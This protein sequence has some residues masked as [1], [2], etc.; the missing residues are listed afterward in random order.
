MNSDIDEIDDPGLRVALDGHVATVEFSRP[1]NNFFDTQLIGL[2]A[3]AMETLASDGRTRAVVWC[4]TGRHFCAGANFAGGSQDGRTAS[5]LY[6]E[7]LRLFS[8][9]LPIVAAVQGAAIGGGLGL[10]LVADFR[11]ASSDARISANFAQLGFHHGFGI[12]VTLPRIVGHQSAM[13]LLYTGR[14]IKGAEALRIGL[15]DQITNPELL[16]ETAFALAGEIATSAPLAVRSIRETL[17]G[18]LTNEVALAVV[19]EQAEQERLMRTLDFREGI[20]AATDR[21]TPN[22]YGK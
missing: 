4:S 19:R 2:I 7:G 14:R 9:P 15:V 11:V 3:D 5:D 18:S 6:K 20:A 10:A 13:D 21:R 22:F 12:S 8:Q 16:R 1:P 17:R